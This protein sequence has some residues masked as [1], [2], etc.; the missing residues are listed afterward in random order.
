MSGDA[1]AGIIPAV[2]DYLAY[3]ACMECTTCGDCCLFRTPPMPDGRTCRFRENASRYC[4]HRA[5]HGS[6]RNRN[7]GNVELQN[8]LFITAGGSGGKPDE[9]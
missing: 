3:R 4:I 9:Y 6:S 2:D 1:N 8:L 5:D 7:A